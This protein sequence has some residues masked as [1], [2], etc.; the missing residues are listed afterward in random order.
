MLDR[1]RLPLEMHTGQLT[2]VQ[3]GVRQDVTDRGEDRF[4]AQAPSDHLRHQWVEDEGVL[5]G[6]DRDLDVAG[7]S[8]VTQLMSG[9]HSGEAASSDDDA[10]GGG[11]FVLSH[12]VFPNLVCRGRTGCRSTNPEL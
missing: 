7:A 1:H 10:S 12:P 4:H 5:A 11:R 8:G 2:D 9:R 3:A 6:D